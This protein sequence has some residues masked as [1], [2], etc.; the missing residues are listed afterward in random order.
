MSARALKLS[1][2]LAMTAVASSFVTASISVVTTG[3][4]G[5]SVSKSVNVA[6]LP[7]PDAKG[8]ISIEVDYEAGSLPLGAFTGTITALDAASSAGAPDVT[9]EGTI[10]DDGASG[11]IPNFQPIPVGVTVTLG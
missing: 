6:D 11:G 3:S 4:D 2:V 10:T 1:I 7:A 8:N 5:Q 9:F